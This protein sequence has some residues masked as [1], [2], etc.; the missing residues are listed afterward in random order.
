MEIDTKEL[1]DEVKEEVL[2][3]TEP[4]E[5]RGAIREPRP[6]E[7][8]ISPEELGGVDVYDEEV[9]A[10]TLAKDFSYQIKDR[11]EDYYYG[12]NV[13]NIYKT[14]NKYYAKV[15]G[16][17]SYN[18]TIEV[19]DEDHAKYDCTC[20]CT[21]PCKHEYAV[22]MAISNL[23]YS[24][25]ELKTP[26]KEKEVNLKSILQEI[27][28]EEIK[29]YLLSPKGLNNVIMETGSFAEYFR[30]YYPKQKY[31]Y[32]YNN[33]YNELILDGNYSYT[34]QVYIDR[35][36]Q[37]LSGDEF[38][39]SFKIAKSIIEAYNDT[40]RLNFDDYVFD[41]INKLGMILRITYRKAPAEVKEDIIKWAEELRE[42]A[43]YN[44]Y[45]LEDII[46][47]LR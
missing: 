45:Y 44:N 29:K 5:I 22:L 10:D 42:K 6:E 15:S 36:N 12:G 4:E 39:E 25:I 3:S 47:S 38:A 17:K 34:L 27:P 40:N 23:E 30:R 11:G 16:N 28:A 9:L 43:Y 1:F 31:E 35:A 37:Y 18:V 19:Q 13:Q 8:A 7:V 14:K 26:I 20:P 2:T 41:M 33:L 21:Y 46:L 24:E 32:Y